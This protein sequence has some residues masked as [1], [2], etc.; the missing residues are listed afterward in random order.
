MREIK[1]RA[2]AKDTKV[3]LPVWIIDFQYKKLQI[4]ASDDEIWI[5]LGK[6]ELMQFTGLRDKNGKEIYEGDIVRNPYGDL[7]II[8]WINDKA[9]FMGEP[10]KADEHDDYDA[11][12]RDLEIVG[13]IYENPELLGGDK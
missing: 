10:I 8:R 6:V 2:W 9:S 4:Y 7:Y 3:M 11:Y 12:V 5:P 1:F 13:N